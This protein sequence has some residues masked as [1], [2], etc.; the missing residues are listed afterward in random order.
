MSK[1]EH[2]DKFEDLTKILFNASSTRAYLKWLKKKHPNSWQRAFGN[3]NAAHLDLAPKRE[4]VSTYYIGVF[5]PDRDQSWPWHFY[6]E[7]GTYLSGK[8]RLCKLPQAKKF[9][10]ADDARQFFHDWKNKK[11]YKME[12]VE[13]QHWEWL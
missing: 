5:D 8:M 13:F 2:K 1:S 12:L 6:N 3:V 9:S 10:N 11:H 4:L 7:N